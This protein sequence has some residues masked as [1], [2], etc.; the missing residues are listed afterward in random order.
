MGEKIKYYYSYFEKLSTNLA[1][2]AGI[3]PFFWLKRVQ[4]MSS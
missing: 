3:S 1:G 4:T 2:G